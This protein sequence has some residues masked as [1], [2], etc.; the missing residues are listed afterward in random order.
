V[1]R[2]ASVVDSNWSKDAVLQLSDGAGRPRIITM[3]ENGAPYIRVLDET[4]AVVMDLPAAARYQ[5]APAP[6]LPVWSP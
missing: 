6:T 5:E 4:G 1:P 2:P 3:P